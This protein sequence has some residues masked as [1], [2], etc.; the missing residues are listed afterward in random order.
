MTRKG[1][2]P[3]IEALS[4][5][6]RQHLLRALVEKNPTGFVD[7]L[8]QARRKSNKQRARDNHPREPERK[9][10]ARD[11]SIGVQVGPQPQPQQATAATADAALAQFARSFGDAW[12]DDPANPAVELVA[13]ESHLCGRINTYHERRWTQRRTGPDAVAVVVKLKDG[14]SETR[15][16]SRDVIDAD[17]KRS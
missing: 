17:W 6:Q 13:A 14:T 11:P 5:E 2:A 16:F 4:E 1:E 8:S 7:L 12:L 15:K 3:D 10:K 9:K